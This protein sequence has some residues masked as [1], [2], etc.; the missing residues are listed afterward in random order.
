MK[1]TRFQTL[2]KLNTALVDLLAAEFTRVTPTPRLVMLSGGKTP[3]AA[4]AQLAARGVTA[5]AH[6][7]LCVSDERAVP[8]ASPE[9][10]AGQLAPLLRA[11][12]L[13]QERTLFPNTALPLAE[14]A[15][16][17]HT[18]LSNFIARGGRPS[19]GLLGLGADGHT[20]SLFTLDDVAR[21]HGALAQP[22]T[23]PAPPNRISVTVDLLEKFERLIFVVAGAEKQ[24]MR[25]RLLH[26]PLTIPAGAATARAPRVECWFAV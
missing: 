4:Y 22:V 14:A 21:G 6:L 3:L 17:W 12:R 19:L 26:A 24:A 1:A 5:E 2:E 10:N 9:H 15:Q 25:D 11:L 13:P 20:A 7:H 23:R 16:A 8:P 18:Q